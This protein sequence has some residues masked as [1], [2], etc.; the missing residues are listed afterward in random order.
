MSIQQTLTR[1]FN[2]I[3]CALAVL[4]GVI[5]IFLMISVTYE[6]FVRYFFNQS[7]RWTIEITGYGMLYLTFLSAVWLLGREEHVHIDLVT[8]H[9]SPR[10]QAMIMVITSFVG[11][12]TCLVIFYFGAKVTWF[13]YRTSYLA[14][15]ELRTPQFLIVLIIPL[16]NL[17]LFIQFLK[18]GC[19]NLV[20][21]RGKRV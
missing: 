1:F 10:G 16:G 9:L 17:L 19:R 21:W 20:L 14:P 2:N 5:I 12:L 3:N 15:T 7:L 18:R 6:V 13:C 4:A 11:A 8:G